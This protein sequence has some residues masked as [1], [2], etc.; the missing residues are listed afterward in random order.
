MFRFAV[1][2]NLDENVEERDQKQD[3]KVEHV[4]DLEQLIDLEKEMVQ[5]KKEAIIIKDIENIEVKS[6]S[7]KKQNVR[8]DNS[9]KGRTGSNNIKKVEDPKNTTPITQFFQFQFKQKNKVNL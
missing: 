9:T 1:K 8:I 4:I 5:V 3:Q 7:T 2:L 6:H